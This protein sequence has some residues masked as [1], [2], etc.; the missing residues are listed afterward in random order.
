MIQNITL[1]GVTHPISF[2]N[3]AQVLYQVRF[4]A[5]MQNDFLTV[6]NAAQKQLGGDAS[7]PFS[8]ELSR[9]VAVGIINGYRLKG[10][11][12]EIDPYDVADN[13]LGDEAA[14]AQAVTIYA[15]SLPKPDN[16]KKPTPGK[17]PAKAAKMK[18]TAK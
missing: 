10:Q 12:V 11:T 14:I 3:A 1:G 5:S 8:L 7:M 9:I 16:E 6:V 4:N 17:V 2:S 18:Q 13:L 15:D